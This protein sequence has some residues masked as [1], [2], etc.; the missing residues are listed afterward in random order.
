MLLHFQNHFGNIDPSMTGLILQYIATYSKELEGQLE[1]PQSIE[2]IHH[3]A[4]EQFAKGGMGPESQQWQW[5]Y[6]FLTCMVQNF[7][8]TIPTIEQIREPTTLALTNEE[9]FWITNSRA[10]S[11]KVD[12]PQEVVTQ[13]L[14]QFMSGD[15]SRYLEHIAIVQELVFQ[16]FESLLVNFG[17]TQTRKSDFIQ[18]SLL[19]Q[20]RLSLGTHYK[21]IVEIPDE[22]STFEPPGLHI[23]LNK[24]GIINEEQAKQLQLLINAMVPFVQDKITFR[25]LQLNLI[26]CPDLAPELH[27]SFHTLLMKKLYQSYGDQAYPNL[28]FIRRIMIHLMNMQMELIC[29]PQNY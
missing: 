6:K 16:N 29:S 19:L 2:H 15:F 8:I 22:L 7:P 23:M 20:I 10:M 24:G 5:L 11:I 21:E 3:K 25:L 4:M 14:S 13:S 18:G 1:N 27:K 28:S 9:H 26:T 12:L 17:V